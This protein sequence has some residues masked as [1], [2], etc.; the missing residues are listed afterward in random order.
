MRRCVLL[1]LVVLLL[2]GCVVDAPPP[3]LLSAAAPLPADAPQ[4][5]LAKPTELPDRFDLP[6]FRRGG[7]LFLP[8]Y[9]DSEAVGMMMIDTGASLAVVAQG[10]AGRLKLESVGRGRT[11]GVGGF[12]EFDYLRVDDYSVGS[13]QREATYPAL[14]RGQLKLGSDRMASLP[15][16]D[17]GRSLSVGLGGIVAYSDLSSVPFTLDASQQLLSVYHPKRFRAPAGSSRHRLLRY[18]QLP[19]VRAQLD[20]HGQKVEVWLIVDYGADIALTLPRSLL[21]Q[22]PGIVAVGAAG[23]GQTRGV[24]G[25]VDSTQTWVSQLNLFGLKLAQ[26]PANF[27]TPPPTLTGDRPIGRV[28]NRLLQH[29]RLTF[30]D[31]HGYIY[32]QWIPADEAPQMPPAPPTT[33]AP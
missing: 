20:D 11:V 4:Y 30:H 13:W 18:R 19:M 8:G 3:T 5:D 23:T 25:I 10:V 1:S 32:S 31:A 14:T 26:L 15:L 16:R 29:F 17:F 12:A 27:E 33:L 7:Y 28:G 24:G 9:I 21:E 22:H 2:A 6:L